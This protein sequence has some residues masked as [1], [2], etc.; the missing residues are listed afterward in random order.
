MSIRAYIESK[1]HQEEK[2]DMKVMQAV[3]DRMAYEK[4]FK[5]LHLVSGQLLVRNSIVLYE[6]LW[7]G[8]ATVTLCN[9]FFCDRSLLLANEL[10]A[11]GFSIFPVRE[12][13]YM[14]DWFVDA[15]GVLGQKKIPQGAVEATRTGHYVYQS[16]NCST[17]CIDSSQIKHLEDYLG[18]GES[19]VRGWKH[20]RPD[21]PITGKK[22]ILF[23]YGKVGRGVAHSTRTHGASVYVID[24]DPKAREK[25]AGENFETIDLSDRQ[26]VKEIL[27]LADIV[28]GATGIHGGV[29]KS[30]P[31][32]WLVQN[33][34]FLVNIGIDEYGDAFGEDEILGGNIPINFHLQQP[35]INRYIDPVHAAL[36][37][38]IEELVKNPNAYSKGVHPLPGSIDEWVLNKWIESWPDEDIS[39]LEKEL[40]L[41]KEKV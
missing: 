27:G 18:T 26:A 6:A 5:G 13:A 17:I 23:G 25:S 7:R 28:I 10:I 21:D 16:V 4:P 14:G 35:T 32:D 30:V 1:E 15:A 2:K 22:V 24:P 33:K 41:I 20:L 36:V 39:N 8:G 40:D 37:L 11:A 34:P 38:G 3:I 31:R 9:P 12:A 19:F 29:S